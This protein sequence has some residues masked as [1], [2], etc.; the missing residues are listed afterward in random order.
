M[1]F[2]QELIEAAQNYQKMTGHALSGVGRQVLNDTKF[3]DRIMNGSGCNIKTYQ[4]VMQWF[5]ENTPKASNK[6]RSN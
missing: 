4:K 3:F 6:H 2:K 1:D 5:Q